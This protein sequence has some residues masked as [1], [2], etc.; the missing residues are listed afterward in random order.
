MWEKFKK[1][2]WYN[3]GCGIRIFKNIFKIK[4]Q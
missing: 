3:G 4:K 2:F 1:W